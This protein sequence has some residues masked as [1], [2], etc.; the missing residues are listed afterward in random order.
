MNFDYLSSLE[1]F[2]KFKQSS[3][4]DAS[5]MECRSSIKEIRDR[6]IGSAQAKKTFVELGIVQ[7]LLNIIKSEDSEFKQDIMTIIGSLES[8]RMKV[9][10]MDRNELIGEILIFLKDENLRSIAARTLKLV[11]QNGITLDEAN[12]YMKNIKLIHKSY[13]NSLNVG[14]KE[15]IL[16]FVANICTHNKDIQTVVS[17]VFLETLIQNLRSVNVSK[18]EI[19]SLAPRCFLSCHLFTDQGQR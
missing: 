16:Y 18:N 5:R 3:Q 17:N 7:E 9:G 1:L 2:Q 12:L 8:S 11:T 10:S 13:Q 4:N 15:N 14:E 6:I 19:N